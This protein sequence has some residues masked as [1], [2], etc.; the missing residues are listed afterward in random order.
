MFAYPG[1]DIPTKKHSATSALTCRNVSL[2]ICKPCGFYTS[3][4]GVVYIELTNNKQLL[5]A[6]YV[7]NDSFPSRIITFE[8]RKDVYLLSTVS[9]YTGWLAMTHACSKLP[10]PYL[11]TSQFLYLELCV[12]TSPISLL[13][14]VR[15]CELYLISSYQHVPPHQIWNKNH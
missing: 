12:F 9:F 11:A 2:W 7:I 4:M 8:A 6:Q 5:C 1:A 13:V 14:I 3:G 15:I 10:Y